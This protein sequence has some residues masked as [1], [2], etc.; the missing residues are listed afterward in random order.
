MQFG[1]HDQ[2]YDPVVDLGDEPPI[3]VGDDR[4]M[5]PDHRRVSLRWLTGTVMTGM[6]S[7]FLMGGALVRGA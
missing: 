6:T 1:W 5:P 7:V 2:D 4:D 3:L